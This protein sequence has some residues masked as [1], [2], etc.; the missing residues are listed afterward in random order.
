MEH[1]EITEI[2]NG[3]F[4]IIPDEGYILRNNVSNTFYVE[5][6]TKNIYVFESVL[7]DDLQ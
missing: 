1:A 2:G 7:K 6:V 3:F 4:K 5:A